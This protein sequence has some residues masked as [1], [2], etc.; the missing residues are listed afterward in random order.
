[1]KKICFLCPG[2][3]QNGG[4]ERV[5]CN[6]ANQFSL[7]GYEVTL[8]VLNK[9][10]KGIYFE[11]NNKIK[12]E[13][14]N[15]LQYKNNG[16]IRRMIGKIL[17]RH[18]ESFLKNPELRKEIFFPKKRRKGLEKYL[19]EKKFDIVIAVAVE[20]TEL[21]SCINTE[22]INTLIIGWQH[23]SFNAYF[24]EKNKYSYGMEK[25]I[26][27]YY[28]NLDKLVLLTKKDK[29]KYE[30][31]GIKKCTYIYNPLSFTSERKAKVINHNIIFVGRLVWEQKG[32]DYL[33]RIM[34][35][36]INK[37]NQKKWNFIIVGDGKDKDKMKEKINKLKLDNNVKFIG[38][39]NNV[40]EYYLESSICINTSRWEG[41]GLVITEAMEC[42]VPVVAFENDGP[43]EIIVNGLNGYIIP[44][45]NI[46]EFAN[47]LY[48][49]MNNIELRKKM[50]KK[51][52]IYMEKFKLKKIFYTWDKLI[53]GENNEL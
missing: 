2:L 21:I 49:L 46:D 51:S 48:I 38:N 13:Y 44:K 11:I 1:M 40:K 24:E 9:K 34:D 42:G 29:E 3:S 25:F 28:L 18:K 20:M 14:L 30:K 52:I 22:N 41:F 32:L 53:K 17:I 15:E 47:K 36:I 45:F 37:Y 19:K 23:N 16:I 8:T 35:I 27:K 10:N 4:L 7:N 43:N 12:L 31:I 33:I 6:L 39:T 26:K 5:V 50:S